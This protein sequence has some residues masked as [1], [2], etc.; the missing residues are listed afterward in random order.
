VIVPGRLYCITKRS[1]QLDII[2]L[3]HNL[4][5]AS[6]KDRLL[7]LSLIAPLMAHVWGPSILVERRWQRSMKK[8]GE[9]RWFAADK[10]MM[11]GWLMIVGRLWDGLVIGCC[12]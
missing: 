10:S 9:F 4:Y 12:F 2:P 3:N 7:T 6:Q 5:F 11:N 8:L 1:H